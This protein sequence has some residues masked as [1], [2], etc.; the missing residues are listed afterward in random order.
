MTRLSVGDRA[1]N[2]TLPDHQ[3]RPFT[4]SDL[5]SKQYVLIVL[6]LGIV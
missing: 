6:N 4:L 1:P 2:Y 5:Y 3:G